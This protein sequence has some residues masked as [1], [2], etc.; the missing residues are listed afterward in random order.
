MTWVK[1]CGLSKPEDVLAA[2]RSGAVAIGFVFYAQ[3]PR[4]VS[5]DQARVLGI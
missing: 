1:V 2:A 3:S 4:L 5:V